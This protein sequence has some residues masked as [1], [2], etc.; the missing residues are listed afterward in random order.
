MDVAMLPAIVLPLQIHNIFTGNPC[1]P[2]VLQSTEHACTWCLIPH[3][4]SIKRL[5]IDAGSPCVNVIPRTGLNVALKF[6]LFGR[7]L[8]ALSLF[9]SGQDLPQWLMRS[10]SDS[11]FVFY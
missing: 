8:H 5:I 9:H 10:V 2:T 6:A 11:G 4:D 3:I 7:N 1:V